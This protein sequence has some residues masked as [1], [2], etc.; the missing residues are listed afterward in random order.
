MS[1]VESLDAT[2]AI[3]TANIINTAKSQ[4]FKVKAMINSLKSFDGVTILHENGVNDVVAEYNGVRYT[5]IFN[6]FVCSHYV[7][8]LYGRLP[9]QHHC[10]NCGAYIP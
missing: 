9:D 6:G 3:G 8:D 5:A 7:D 1:T 2:E 10:P 4:G